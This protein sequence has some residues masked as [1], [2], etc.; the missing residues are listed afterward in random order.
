MRR[1]F[2]MAVFAALLSVWPAAAQDAGNGL[3]AQPAA[4]VVGQCRRR[5]QRHPLRL[6]GL[7]R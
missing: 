1:I 4:G 2:T 3:R 6:P 5:F 7:R